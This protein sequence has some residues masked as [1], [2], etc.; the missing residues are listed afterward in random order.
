MG[1]SAENKGKLDA[2]ILE[3]LKG[4]LHHKIHYEVRNFE[5]KTK[6]N[7]LYF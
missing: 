3:P 2:L 5:R 4:S 7:K 6:T 1:V